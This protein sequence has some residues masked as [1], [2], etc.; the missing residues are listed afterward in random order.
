[1]TPLTTPNIPAAYTRSPAREAYTCQGAVDV[2]GRHAAFGRPFV[3]LTR[4]RFLPV[5]VPASVPVPPDTV[6][7]LPPR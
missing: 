3:A 2:V 6:L 1:M 7:T 5:T 4:K